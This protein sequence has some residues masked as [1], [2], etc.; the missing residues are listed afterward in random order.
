MQDPEYLIVKKLKIYI[1]TIFT[2]CVFIPE[3]IETDDFACKGNK[4][5]SKILSHFDEPKIKNTFNFKIN[6]KKN[7]N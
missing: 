4:T 6:E 5:L 7:D 2:L 3:S 1:Q